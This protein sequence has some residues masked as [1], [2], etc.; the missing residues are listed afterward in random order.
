MFR[1]SLLAALLF[2]FSLSVGCTALDDDDDAVT[3]GTSE[4]AVH[5]LSMPVAVGEIAGEGPL[6]TAGAYVYF[7]DHRSNTVRR[8]PKAGGPKTIVLKAGNTLG[9]FVLDA[10]H[11]YAV[12]EGAGSF[13]RIVRAPL[14]G[15]PIEEMLG[16][17]FDYVTTLA[18]D[19][20][21]VY[22]AA[23][24]R[25][26]RFPKSG[27][28]TAP[29]VIADGQE[30]ARGIALDDDNVYW[31]TVG[32]GNAA[33]GCTPGE[34]RVRARRKD[35]GAARIVAQG[36]D[37]PLWL[38]LDGASLYWRTFTGLLRAARSAS[39]GAWTV[40]HDV[41]SA[42]AAFDGTAVYFAAASPLGVHVYRS[43]KLVPVP[44]AVLAS[45]VS[46]DEEISTLTVSGRD[47]FYLANDTTTDKSRLLRLR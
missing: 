45:A 19:A 28:F 10:K 36:E 38:G 44:Q 22:A 4:D 14:A 9:D 34:G 2:S 15:G 41:V 1:S 17:E 24:A 12:V 46:A 47:L 7:R 37:C 26:V 11:V 8:M 23:G 35:G 16:G 25:V 33:I 42:N 30:D 6:R 5:A 27:A 32:P 43:S 29:E 31:S 21:H 3:P 13:G 20:T 40:A 18:T 39:G